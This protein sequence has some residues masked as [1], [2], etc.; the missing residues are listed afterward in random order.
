M[1]LTRFA[2][3]RPSAVFVDKPDALES[4]I[5]DGL[6]EESN[7]G[8][9]PE[10]SIVSQSSRVSRGTKGSVRSGRSKGSK[11]SQKSASQEALIESMKDRKK[12]NRQKFA[13]EAARKDLETKQCIERSI[14]ARAERKERSFQK[15]IK[16]IGTAQSLLD[17]IDHHL[18]LE[19]ETK[20]NKIRRQW[21]DW[22]TNVHGEIQ[23][24][25]LKQVAAVSSK[26]LN[27]KKNEDYS[28]FIEI[29]NR[30][31]AIFR[32]IIIESEYDPLEPNRNSIVAKTGRLKD[33]TLMQ[34][35]KV[36]EEKGMVPGMGVGGSDEKPPLGKDTLTVEIWASGKIEGTPHGR[37]AKMMGGSSSKGNPTS[38]SSVVFDDYNYPTGP[39]SLDAELP[40]GKRIYPTIIYA[41]PGRVMSQPQDDFSKTIY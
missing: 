20:H 2:Y 26:D 19:A 31:P 28:K 8:I 10:N 39:V 38:R 29:T 9:R 12:Q 6:A 25:I 36:E 11:I 3:P 27:K 33:P 16:S 32:D 41:N 4:L 35:R 23:K 17:E 40:K 5:E 1:P 13:A 7:F 21:E 18:S 30:K 22:N 37:F 24:R 15:N 14:H 34:L